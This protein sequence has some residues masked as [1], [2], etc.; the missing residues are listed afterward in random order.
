MLLGILLTLNQ[1]IIINLFLLLF[2]RNFILA[3]MLTRPL[4]PPRVACC[5]RRGSGSSARVA[6]LAALVAL[7][8][9][10]DSAL[11]IRV[12]SRRGKH[13]GA[14]V[15]RITLALATPRT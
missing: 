14:A 15:R 13:E 6:D 8:G 3:A 4:P 5:S 2:N 10:E 11:R 9:K 1:R 12:R 7:V